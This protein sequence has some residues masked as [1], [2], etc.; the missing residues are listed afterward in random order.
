MA[1]KR[2]ISKKKLKECCCH[3]TSEFHRWFSLAILLLGVWYVLVDY[4]YSAIKLN[5]WSAV[6]LLLG[7]KAVHKHWF[8]Q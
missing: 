2:K 7:I 5:W 3:C 6:F 8:H 4:G 1:K